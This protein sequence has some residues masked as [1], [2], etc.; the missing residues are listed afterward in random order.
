MNNIEFQRES[1]QADVFEI[2]TMCK[3]YAVDMISKYIFA[4]DI[5]SFKENQRNSEF[6]KLALR[7]GDVK[8]RDLLLLEFVP[9]FLQPLLNLNIFD[10]EPLDK[11]GDLFKR[12]VRERDPSLRYNDLT[13]LLKDQIRD[14]KLRNMSEDEIVA[15]CLL[16]FFAGS[17]TTSNALTRVFYYLVTEPKVQMRLQE[18]LRNEFRDGITYERLVEH[19]FLDAFVSECLRLGQSLLS[20]D[21]L[22]TKDTQLGE[23]KLERGVVVHL[24]SYL[25]HVSE[26]Y[27]PDPEK[28]DV[29]RFLDKSSSNPNEIHRSEIYSPFSTG[30]R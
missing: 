26:K 18:E 19:P 28:F 10:V 9:N 2:R 27:W 29:N 22:V 16:G 6:V 1:D 7:V 24:I 14:G 4:V 8:L 5:D 30:N 12:M 15:N 23:Y 20:L 25:N 3:F 11:L 17:D 21:R 13:E